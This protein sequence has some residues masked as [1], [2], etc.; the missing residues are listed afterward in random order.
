[1]SIE[2]VDTKEACRILGGNRPLDRRLLWKIVNRD[3]AFPY[4]K[5]G[6]SNRYDKRDLDRYVASRKRGKAA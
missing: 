3:K 4:Y 5:I 1:M 2:L 6:G